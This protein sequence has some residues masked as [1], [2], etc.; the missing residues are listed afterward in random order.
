M[1]ELRY[2]T[3]SPSETVDL[4][5]AMGKPV[6]AKDGQRIGSIASFH[7]DPRT[8]VVEGIRVNRGI[9]EPLE[10]IGREYVY[11]VSA[12]GVVLEVAPVTEIV[13]MRVYDARGKFVGEVSEIER[14]NN[15]NELVNIEVDRGLFKRS[16]LLPRDTIKDVG[17]GVLL[18]VAVRG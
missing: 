17:K 15:T 12:R 4:A 9:F 1:L 10:Y 11:S 7:A 18:N 14:R 5:E 13:G 6:I 3:K 8:L 16:I 2:K